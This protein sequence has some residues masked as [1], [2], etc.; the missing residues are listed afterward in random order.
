MRNIFLLILCTVI[1]VPTAALAQRRCDGGGKL[2]AYLSGSIDGPRPSA[3]AEVWVKGAVPGDV[4]PA[5]VVALRA[6][7]EAF[8][9]QLLSADQAATI[10]AGDWT[11]WRAKLMSRDEFISGFLDEVRRRAGSQG[12]YAAILQAAE[13]MRNRLDDMNGAAGARG[14]P[15]DPSA[16]W[17]WDLTMRKPAA[18][19]QVS[20]L[21]S[22][23]DGKW[24]WNR[25]LMGRKVAIACALDDMSALTLLAATVDK[26]LFRRPDVVTMLVAGR[27][28]P[29]D[30]PVMAYL[31]GLLE[32]RLPN[33]KLTVYPDGWASVE[34][35][36]QATVQNAMSS[37]FSRGFDLGGV[38]FDSVEFA[39]NANTGRADAEALEEKYGCTSPVALAFAN[40]LVRTVRVD[41]SASS[42]SLFVQSCSVQGLSLKQCAC[43]AELGR[44]VAPAIEKMGYNPG[45]TIKWIT[46]RN[47]SVTIQIALLCGIGNY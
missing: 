25:Y 15:E 17:L 47:P 40:G 20:L 33:C 13:A 10:A 22:L 37:F 14:R 19:D 5:S 44:G 24:L 11:G 27:K 42:D 34:R 31:S 32:V 8:E 28:V 18:K 45:T 29:L 9:R 26:S 36:Q 3:I 16:M 12:E 21:L 30:Y 35:F 23:P 7:I 6:A 2:P 39:T 43:L 1:L 4:D 46:L 38:V 41:A